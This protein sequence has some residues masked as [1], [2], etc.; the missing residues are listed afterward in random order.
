MTNK[1][2]TRVINGIHGDTS[3]MKMLDFSYNLTETA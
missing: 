3:G 2:G 1:R